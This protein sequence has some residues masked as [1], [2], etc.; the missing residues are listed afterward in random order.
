LSAN[1]CDL[2][3]SSQL[4]PEI[5]DFEWPSTCLTAKY[6]SKDKRLIK[7]ARSKCLNYI[8][9]IKHHLIMHC[10]FK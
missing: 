5:K 9:A 6:V 4:V 7:Y 1:Y 2:L 8:I 3:D 10:T